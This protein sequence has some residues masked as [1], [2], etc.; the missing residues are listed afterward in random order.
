MMRSQTQQ[1]QVAHNESSYFSNRHSTVSTEIF[2]H[3]WP[4]N[5]SLQLK[6]L[7]KRTKCLVDHYLANPELASSELR[8]IT[9]SN[10][11]MEARRI[12]L[13]ASITASAPRS[14]WDAWNSLFG[15]FL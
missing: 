6:S 15:K 1:Y 7:P 8:S 12:A 2:F 14:F 10:D 3:G 11:P 9:L 4:K 13:T 5:R